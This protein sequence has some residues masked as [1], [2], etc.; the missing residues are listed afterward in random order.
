MGLSVVTVV[1]GGLPVADVTA[2]TPK[3]GLP[4]DEATNGR[5][6][7][8]TRAAVGKPGLPMTWVTGGVATG[9][10]ATFDGV[11][12][13]VTLSNGNRTATHSTATSNSGAR[14]TALKTTGKYYFEITVSTLGSSFDAAGLITSTGTYTDVMSVFNCIIVYMQGSVY[15]NNTSP[16]KTISGIVGGSILGFAT[17][18]D[19]RLGWIRNGAGSWNGIGTENP[20]TG[21]G[22]FVIAPTVSFAPMVAFDTVAGAA[23]TLNCGQAAYVNAAPSGFGD[24]K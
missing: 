19:T 16:G 23:F 18:L 12:V 4:V 13:N 15:A 7:A 11:G 17:N 5:G 22:G 2:T 6:L 9:V 10:P 20:A 24:W 3:F 14:S 8:V 1:S 21:V